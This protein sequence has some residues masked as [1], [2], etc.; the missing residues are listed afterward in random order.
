MRGVRACPKPG[1]GQDEALSVVAHTC[2]PKVCKVGNALGYLRGLITLKK[3]MQ[4]AVTCLPCKHENI[5]S[6]HRK[7]SREPP[8]PASLGKR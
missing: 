8:W 4:E 2:H 3:K 7:P 5:V 6:T 1:W